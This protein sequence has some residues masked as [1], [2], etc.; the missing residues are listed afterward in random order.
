MKRFSLIFFVVFFNFSFAQKGNVL[1]LKL[2]EGN[3][4]SSFLRGKTENEFVL[5]IIKK[6]DSVFNLD[7]NKSYIEIFDRLLRKESH[8]SSAELQALDPEFRREFEALQL[9]V[10][11]GYLV[12]ILKKAVDVNFDAGFLSIFLQSKNLKN[13]SVSKPDF[14][15]FEIK[16]STAEDYNLGKKIL[17]QNA[18]FFSEPMENAEL[19]GIKN[20]IIKANSELQKNFYIKLNDGEYYFSLSKD[21][22]NQVRNSEETTKCFDSKTASILFDEGYDSENYSKLYLVKK[23]KDLEKGLIENVNAFDFKGETSESSYKD[24]LFFISIFTNEKAQ[25]SLQEFSQRNLGK[26][27]F[28]SNCNNLILNPEVSV[29]LEEGKILFTGNLFDEKWQ[30]FFKAIQFQVFKNSIS[31]Q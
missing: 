1:K 30:E 7:K 13:F 27:I 31:F 2:N 16:F 11:N 21:F 26:N 25:K 10:E 23:D 22:T 28:I 18:L 15:L 12:E 8:L 4:I 5:D 9:Q 29:V 24:N 19:N 17:S 3:F 6:T 20:C 14:N